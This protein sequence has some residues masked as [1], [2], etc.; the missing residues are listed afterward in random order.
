MESRGRL[1]REVSIGGSR[2]KK[3]NG[4]WIRKE[5]RLQAAAPDLYANRPRGLFSQ[6]G[7]GIER[8]TRIDIPWNLEQHD[9]LEGAENGDAVCH[10]EPPVIR[11]LR[12]HPY[13]HQLYGGCRPDRV[14]E[15]PNR[16]GVRS[17]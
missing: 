13:L 5:R 4:T 8:G 6:F 10:Q 2:H 12:R 17:E 14:G 11:Y 9:R 15:H 16:T 7:D 3:G 1:H